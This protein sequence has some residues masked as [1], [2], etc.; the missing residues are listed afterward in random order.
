MTKKLNWIDYV[1]IVGVLLVGIMA[2]FYLTQKDEVRIESNKTE[3][4]IYAEAMNILPE[5]VDL[6]KVGDKVVALG[7]YQDAVIEEV[8]VE[9]YVY[10][11]AVNGELKEF[12][13]ATRKRVVVK[14]TGMAN[15]YGPYIDLGGQEIKAGSKYYIKTD[16]FEAYGNVM[17]VSV[18]E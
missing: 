10:M 8:Q 3:I 11:D 12:E 6:I 9:D 16:H 14:I 2:V 7:T 1:L 18:N 5:A 17:T 4:T 15:K 13:S